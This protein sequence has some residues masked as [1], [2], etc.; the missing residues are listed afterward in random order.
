MVSVADVEQ[1]A[2]RFAACRPRSEAR[3]LLPDH[4]RGI[5]IGADARMA[6]GKALDDLPTIVRTAVIDQDD[7]ILFS[8]AGKDLHLDAGAENDGEQDG[9]RSLQ[10][11]EKAREEREARAEGAHDVGAAGATAP[12]RPRVGTAG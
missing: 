1:L 9:G 7:L 3:R 11:V 12:D 6:C 2:E 5:A 8:Q 10:H 4:P